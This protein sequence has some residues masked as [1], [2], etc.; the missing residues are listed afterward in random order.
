M[1]NPSLK[2]PKKSVIPP[3]LNKTKLNVFYGRCST[4]K[5]KNSIETQMD[6]VSNYCSINDIVLDEI[7]IDDGVIKVI[8]F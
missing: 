8:K 6:L 3:N 1:T 7:I 5:Q 4:S 2:N